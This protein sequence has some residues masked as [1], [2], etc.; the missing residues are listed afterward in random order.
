MKVTLYVV[1][2]CYWLAE[3]F[4]LEIKSN[5][6]SIGTGVSLTEI[7]NTLVVDK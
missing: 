5:N 4:K 6:L 3:V 2:V 1:K 7:T